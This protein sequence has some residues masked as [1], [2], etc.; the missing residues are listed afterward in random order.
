MK[1]AREI[2]ED[3]LALGHI[4]RFNRP[5][6]PPGMYVY[7]YANG[8]S[9]AQA[10]GAL[11]Y[12]MGTTLEYVLANRLA[13]LTGD[14]GMDAPPALP[15]GNVYGSGVQGAQA[16]PAGP[17]DPYSPD[18]PLGAPEVPDEERKAA[19]LARVASEGLALPGDE[20]KL[21][22]ALQRWG[23]GS[24]SWADVERWMGAEPGSIERAARA[25]GAIT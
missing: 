9:A 25:A 18:D 16:P 4:D 10:D 2:Q 3:L 1:S 20:V 13:H 11:G 6:N 19:F 15:A 7:F 17:A 8:V 12:R 14:T 22:F 21:F 23:M 5:L 24:D